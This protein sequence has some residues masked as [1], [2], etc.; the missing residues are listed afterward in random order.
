MNIH[1]LLSKIRTAT[2]VISSLAFI[3]SVPALANLSGAIFTTDPWGA[4]V[5]ENVRYESKL[6]VF[7]DGGPGPHAPRTAAALPAGLYY[8]QVTDPS[9]KCLLSSMTDSADNNGNA[10]LNE[11]KEQL[12]QQLLAF[13][14]NTRHR[15]TD[16]GLSPTT[17]LWYGGEWVPVQEI[18]ANAIVAWQGSDESEIDY[19]KTLLDGMNNNDEVQI[20]PSSPDDCPTPYFPPSEPEV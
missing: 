3:F 10:D 18:I 13:I 4:V 8:F 2:L 19:I 12:A 16:S 5:N 9:G 1:R 17:T 6:E 20:L 7:L 14:F 15:P 11:H